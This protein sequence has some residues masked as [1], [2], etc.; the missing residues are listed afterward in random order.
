MAHLLTSPVCDVYFEGFISDTL[1]LSRTGW[2]ISTQHD[3]YTFRTEMLLYHEK[4]DMTLLANSDDTERFMLGN[5][6]QNQYLQDQF[7][8]FRVHRQRSQRMILPKTYAEG[9]SMWDDTKPAFIE[10]PNMPLNEIPLFSKIDQPAGKELIVDQEEVSSLLERIMKIQS[11]GQ[12]EIRK[13]NQKVIPKIHAS[14]LSF[15]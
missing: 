15:G 8:T 9:F 7:P 3:T 11:P 5:R 2:K 10:V 6:F 12:A 14:I 1:K 4:L 13:K